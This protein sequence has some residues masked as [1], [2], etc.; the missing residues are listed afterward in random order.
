MDAAISTR[1]RKGPPPA[2]VITLSP[3]ERATLEHLCRAGTTER[4]LADRAHVVLL[5]V[6]GW[7]NMAIAAYLHR[8]RYWV[9]YW[10]RRFG[11]ERLPGLVDRP[12]SGRPPRLSPPA[13]S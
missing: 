13:A 2:V 9:Q 10:R 3:E 4:R 11:R 12:R 8:T 5:A 6:Q 1:R 7:G